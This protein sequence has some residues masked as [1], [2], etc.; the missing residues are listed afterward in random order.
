LILIDG[1]VLFHTVGERYLPVRD[2]SGI[3][4]CKISRELDKTV[5][6]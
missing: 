4:G 5:N 2:G 1:I 3:T 6:I